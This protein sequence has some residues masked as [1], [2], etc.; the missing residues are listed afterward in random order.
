MV[1]ISPILTQTN[2]RFYWYVFFSQVLSLF[3]K[4]FII[5]I[6]RRAWS[7]LGRSAAISEHDTH[8]SI[9]SNKVMQTKNGLLIP[10]QHDCVWID[11][12]LGCVHSNQPTPY[13]NIRRSQICGS[14]IGAQKLQIFYKFVNNRTS[15]LD[16]PRNINHQTNNSITTPS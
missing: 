14:Y 12:N 2:S 4:Y 11:K 10:A 13:M 6:M 1:T 5:E 8:S 16:I 3:N 15:S 7:I 9:Q